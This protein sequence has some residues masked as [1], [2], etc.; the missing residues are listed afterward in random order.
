MIIYAFGSNDFGQI[1]ASCKASMFREAVD[2]T[3]LISHGECQILYIAAGG[4]QSFAVGVKDDMNQD[5]SSTKSWLKRQFS[6]KV[7]S[8]P[9]VI[10]ASNLLTLLNAAL[11]IAEIEKSPVSA[12]ASGSALSV[13]CEIF[14]TPSLLAGSFLDLKGLQMSLTDDIS[15]NKG[16]HWGTDI[17]VDNED[18]KGNE[19]LNSNLFKK[20]EIKR[21]SRKEGYIGLEKPVEYEYRDLQIDMEGVEACYIMLMQMGKVYIYIYIYIYSYV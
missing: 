6:T 1:D 14:G 8:A 10:S 15:R 19:K 12:S 3:S 16:L 20:N 18:N 13:A 7:S 2:I 4:D 5:N 11:K 21:K 17:N 9:T